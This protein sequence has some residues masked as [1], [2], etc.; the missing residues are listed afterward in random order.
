MEEPGEVR[1][2]LLVAPK[3]RSSFARGVVLQQSVMSGTG[4]DCQRCQCECSSAF[5]RIGRYAF[6]RINHHELGG[7]SV[8]CHAHGV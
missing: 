5:R 2:N 4:I 7:E 8:A 6:K 1:G 3:S